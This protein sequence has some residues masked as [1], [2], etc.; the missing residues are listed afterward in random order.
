MYFYF[1]STQTR[2]YLGDS[3]TVYT[4]TDKKSCSDWA[5]VA[6]MPLKVKCHSQKVSNTLRV[7]PRNP[8]YSAG[9]VYF[10]HYERLVHYVFAPQCCRAHIH[11]SWNIF[12]A[13]HISGSRQLMKINSNTEPFFLQ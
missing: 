5:K 3:V 1:V 4:Y 13:T 2:S 9:E 7:K 10:W 11:F 8:L 6:D 12:L